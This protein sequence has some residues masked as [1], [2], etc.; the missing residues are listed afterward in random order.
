MKKHK[1]LCA[2]IAVAILLIALL[3]VMYLGRY[4][5]PTGDDYFY[6]V[7][8][9]RVWQDTH[10]I[11]AVLREAAETATEQYVAW[12][13]TY[14]ALFLMSLAPNVFGSAV[15]KWFTAVILA[16][17]TGA[18][19]YLVNA[20]LTSGAGEKKSLPMRVILPA[21]L[22]LLCI[23]GV[24][25]QGE[26]FFWYNGSMYY[27]GFFALTLVYF[28]LLV[29][30]LRR[31]NAGRGFLL[32]ALA[33][34]I[35]GGNYVSLLPAILMVC[36][37]LCQSVWK[38]NRENVLLLTENLLLLLAGL[39]VSAIAP[40]NQVRQGDLWK[41]P[42]WKAIVKSLVQ[43]V[44]Y[45]TAWIDWRWLL[46]AVILIPLFWRHYAESRRTF[47]RPLLFCGLVYGIFCSM[48]C[49]TFYTM[50]STGPARAVAI[51]YYG[52]VLAT[53][54][55]VYY[56]EGWVYRRKESGQLPGKTVWNRIGAYSR[57]VWAAAGVI[58]VIG[59]AASGQLRTCTTAK[60]CSLLASGEACAYEQE[61]QERLEILENGVYEDVTFAPYTH[62]PDML[63]VGDFSTDPQQVTN[64]KIAQ[65]FGK[66][67]VALTVE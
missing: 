40:G 61:Y 23:E 14:S 56:V 9:H 33:V 25:S 11:I 48:S 16:A 4:N 19:F 5:H 8:T 31:S 21:V 3:P 53:F 45:L 54:G 36:C 67:S 37:L 62:Q 22:A 20:L 18:L 15:Y 1:N 59:L 51:V 65:F 10:N 47:C 32:A 52:F 38:K 26:T 57:P 43:G 66:R 12:Q 24:P 29:R 39:G 63:Y 2:W 44:R 46:A 50:N 42:A 28:G 41:I 64:V 27:T 34:V 7:D 6:T 60:A 55:C 13:G 30:S 17:L 58:V 49:P 35:A